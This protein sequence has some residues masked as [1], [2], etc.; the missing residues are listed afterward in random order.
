MIGAVGKLVLVLVT[1]TSVFV[2]FLLSPLSGKIGFH[3]WLARVDVRSTG[4]API[5]HNGVEWG[6]DVG[7]LYAE[8]TERSLRG[9]TALITGANSGVGFET[10]L[11]LARLGVSVTLACR[12]P[13]RCARAAQR[14]ASDPVYRAAAAANTAQHRGG[15]GGEVRTETLDTSSSRSVRDFAER[16]SAS[17]GRLDVLYL[18]AGVGSAGVAA[19]G[20]SAPPLSEDGIEKVFATNYLG[21]YLLYRWLEPLLLS[22]GDDDDVDDVPPARVVST[23]SVSSFHTVAHGVS[24]DLATLNAQRPSVRLYGQSKLAQILWTKEVD[25][26]LSAAEKKEEEEERRSDGN[27][28]RRRRRRPVYVNAAHPGAVDTGIWDANPS[29]S[30][31]FKNYVLAPLRRH[32]MW[33]AAEGALTMLYLGVATDEL[34][35]KNVR[36]K[37]FFPQSKEV[38]NPLSLDED[39]QQRL[40]DFSESLVK[41]FL[42]QRVEQEGGEEVPFR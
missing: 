10:A 18:N 33:T 30:A 26:R 7:R 23:T 4:L 12:D 2:G 9:Q 14:I 39:L 37:L 40:W 27:G 19:D 20:S 6:Y 8:G 31:F 36:G 41:D 29:F 42:P 22:Y 21:H 28:R 15:G 5:L 16:F 1:A 24:T 25:R 11:A 35:S 38:V 3:A 17:R 32:V 34:V 13:G